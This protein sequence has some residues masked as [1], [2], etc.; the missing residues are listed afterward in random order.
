MK[1]IIIRRYIYLQN[2]TGFKINGQCLLEEM[3]CLCSF[4]TQICCSDIILENVLKKSE[5]IKSFRPA[6]K[7]NTSM[8]IS[9]KKAHPRG[10]GEAYLQSTHLETLSSS[11]LRPGLGG[12]EIKKIPASLWSKG[13]L[14]KRPATIRVN[15]R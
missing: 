15:A 6:C 11:N 12:T 3:T 8:C 4:C 5:A 1:C 10:Q 2:N 7:A 13:S 14:G 9:L